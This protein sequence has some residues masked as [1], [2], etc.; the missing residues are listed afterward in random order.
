MVVGAT[1]CVDAFAQF[2]SAT[3]LILGVFTDVKSSEN[4]IHRKHEKL[5]TNNHVWLRAFAIRASFVVG[6]LAISS[7]YSSTMEF[8]IKAQFEKTVTSLTW[9]Q[10]ANSREKDN[11]KGQGVHLL[12]T[13]RTERKNA[14]PNRT[15][16]CLYQISEYGIGYFYHRVTDQVSWF[17]EALLR[18]CCQVFRCPSLTWLL[19]GLK[20]IR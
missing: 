1:L 9:R 14:T 3:N 15:T 6:S 17:H 2:A 4:I 16:D 11:T 10:D 8:S 7:L 19:F 20:W 18:S 13:R 5:F 12:A